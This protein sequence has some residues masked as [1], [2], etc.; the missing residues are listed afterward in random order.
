M[1]DEVANDFDAL[2]YS[3]TTARAVLDI[4]ALVS[5]S[6]TSLNHDSKVSSPCHFSRKAYNR[7]PSLCKL[8][9]EIAP[10]D[11]HA[12][13]GPRGVPKPSYMGH[14]SIAKSGNHCFFDED[15]VFECTTKDGSSPGMSRC[16]HFDPTCRWVH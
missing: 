4:L 8:G 1:I 14:K 9:E 15:T 11:S 6:E 13:Y 10:T 3:A 5:A 7:Q 12:A 16:D 2:E